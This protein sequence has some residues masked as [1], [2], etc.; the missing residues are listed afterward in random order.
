MLIYV[1]FELILEL[2]LVTFGLR[3]ATREGKRD[4]MKI[5]CFPKGDGGSRG[6]EAPFGRPESKKK[7]SRKPDPIR[8]AIFIDF[9]PF[10]NHFGG[11]FDS[12]I[13]PKS[14]Q[15]RDGFWSPK[16]SVR[17]VWPGYVPVPGTPP[18]YLLRYPREM[19]SDTGYLRNR[20]TG[21]WGLVAQD[22]TRLG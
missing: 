21:D 18:G 13:H 19:K 3:N 4:F 5:L 1:D 2:V 15:F 12:E 16:K 8:T 22:L 9:I 7:R 6:S 14:R 20:G 17:A 10:W 11:Q